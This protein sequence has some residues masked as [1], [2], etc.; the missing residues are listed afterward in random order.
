MYVIN[1]ILNNDGTS[2]VDY[3][4]NP[5]KEKWSKLYPPSPMPQF[6]QVCDGYSCMWCGRCPRGEYWKVP[7]EDKEVW[8]AYQK[9]L[10]DYNI[11]HGNIIRTKAENYLLNQE[12]NT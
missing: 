9:E 5:L 7:E 6:S 4:E 3:P 10:Y 1:E 12:G 2:M 11:N 8:E